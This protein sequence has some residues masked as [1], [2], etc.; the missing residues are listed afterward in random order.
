MFTT[1]YSFW[2]EHDLGGA[3][4]ISLPASVA[5]FIFHFL[6]LIYPNLSGGVMK[7]SAW[8]FKCDRK[9]SLGGFSSFILLLHC[10]KATELMGKFLGKSPP[11][12]GWVW[13]YG[14]FFS[15]LFLSNHVPYGLIFFQPEIDS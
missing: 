2:H 12:D 5:Q 8:C 14:V 11:R 15:S 10:D 13:W 4:N 7:G 1:I 3:C 6:S 9:K